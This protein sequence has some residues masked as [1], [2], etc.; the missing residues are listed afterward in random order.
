[1]K[2]KWLA[3]LLSLTA[4]SSVSLT[5]CN[6]D[7]SSSNSSKP[8]GGKE[9]A[10]EF[11]SVAELVENQAHEEKKGYKFCGYFEDEDFSKRV[12]TAVESVEDA[13]NYYAKYQ[14]DREQMFTYS[15]SYKYTSLEFENTIYATNY[16]DAIHKYL[17]YS[18]SG[19][20][21]LQMASRQMGYETFFGNGLTKLEVLMGEEGL[22]KSFKCRDTTEY[23]YNTQTA[24][25]YEKI[26][27]KHSNKWKAYIGDI[28]GVED[29][30][31]YYI[32]DDFA[33]I[34]GYEAEDGE[35]TVAEA[36]IPEKIDGKTVKEVSIYADSTVPMN[37]EKISVPST[38]ENFM[39]YMVAYQQTLEEIAFEEGVQTI[40][41]ASTQTEK[42]NI[43]A[44]AYY[45][46][47]RQPFFGMNAPHAY[48]YQ[49]NQDL[50]V[51]EDSAH[52]YTENGFLMSAEGD[53]VH[54]FSNREKIN[55]EIP[56]E[57]KRVL[58]RS[59][60]GIA[61]NIYIPDSVEVFD[62]YYNEYSARYNAYTIAT[63]PMRA[64]I[65]P[66]YFIEN[67]AL[68][69]AWEGA[70]ENEDAFTAGLMHTYAFVYF[71]EERQDISGTQIPCTIKGNSIGA[72]KRY[73]IEEQKYENVVWLPYSYLNE[74]DAEKLYEYDSVLRNYYDFVLN[75][76]RNAE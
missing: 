8:S 42:I 35:E 40:Q 69:E 26:T 16:M 18:R 48:L 43:P 14:P 27:V 51:A 38:V 12:E 31:Q 22:N 59:V 63:T 23:Q 67:E 2:R 64:T 73:N 28:K 36:E 54:Q 6:G 68:L 75:Y 62:L 39:L 29:G 47:L 32:V 46:D 65:L 9:P 21:Y 74:D 25:G 50:T 57:T 7:G 24:E 4:F 37:I 53:L 56:E 71:N 5:A 15:S 44:S 30:W 41:I 55:L 58:R 49:T 1:M 13:E 66:I 52:Y 61:K 34:V 72:T 11:S 60:N 20:L 70:H 3:L 33:V 10:S 76:N 19:E 45:I 17:Y